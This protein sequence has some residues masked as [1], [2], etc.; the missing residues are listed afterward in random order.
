L[1]YD[2]G[3]EIQAL[4]R[5]AALHPS[6][7]EKIESIKKKFTDLAE[8]FQKLWYYHPE[9]KCSLSQKKIYQAIFG[10]DAYA[11]MPIH[12]GML[13]SYRYDDL[14]QETDLFKKQETKENLIQYCCTDTQVM[15]ELFLFL[16][17]KAADFAG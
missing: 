2:T 11:R 3:Q 10:K 4:N 7:K 15:F 6:Y 13:A 5:I 1:V 12:S 8:P 17:K 16:K 14:L 9:Q